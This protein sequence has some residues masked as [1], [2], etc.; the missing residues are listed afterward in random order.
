MGNRAAKD[1]LFDGF[2]AVAKALGNGRRAEIIDVLAQ[3]ERHLDDIAAEIGQSVANL[4]PSPSAR[5]R[6]LGHDS[7]GLHPHVLPARL[8]T[9]GFVVGGT[10]WGRCDSP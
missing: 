6:R 4:L 8:R 1:D 5:R 2:A 9:G 3:R 10:S 7:A